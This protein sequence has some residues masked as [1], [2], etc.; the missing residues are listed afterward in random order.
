MIDMGIPNRGPQITATTILFLS[1]SWMVVLARCYARIF[2]TKNFYLDDFLASI[3]L[4]CQ[5]C[6]S[7]DTFSLPSI[8][9][10]LSFCKN[11]GLTLKILFT[12]YGGV[13]IAG[14]YFGA[15]R[16]VYDLPPE[17]IKAALKVRS[18]SA[19]RSNTIPDMI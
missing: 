11:L 6:T 15:G 14:V 1:L 9:L 19:Y 2:V 4:V 10:I 12:A 13:G 16:H 5:N 8:Y 18:T 3:C 7:C 17:G